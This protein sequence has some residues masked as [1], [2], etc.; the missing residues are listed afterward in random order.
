MKRFRNKPV[1]LLSDDGAPKILLYDI[2]TAPTLAWVWSAY[3]TNV[4]A[5]EQDW[6]MLCFAYKWLGEDET[7]Y[8][9]IYQ[10]PKFRK[11]TANDKFV[12]ERLAALFDH[13][14]IL[15]AH[16]G[17]KFDSRKANA[18]FLFHGIEPP[19]PY[20]Q[21]D[22]LKESRVYF[23]Q[24]KHSL[25]ELGR[26]LGLG[27]K[28]QTGGFQLWRD[29]MYGDADAWALMEEYTVQDVSV[30]EAL[31]IKLR[32]WMG[33]PGKTAHPNIGFWN[34]GDLMCPKCGNGSVTIN[35]WDKLHRTS[36]S[37]FPTVKCLAKDATVSNPCG[38]YSRLRSRLRQVKGEGV[39]AV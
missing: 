20:Q 3:K 14:D 39:Q 4:V 15:I 35:R 6:Y 37:E 13:A 30:L 29:C 19:S 31:Y 8:V 17:N 18:R 33:S 26:Q 10:D 23:G 5:V 12:A 34:K 1:H 9:S 11:D 7:H 27:V 25:N 38:G 28:V 2:E 22:T 21:I 24:F 32:P 36:V 16:N